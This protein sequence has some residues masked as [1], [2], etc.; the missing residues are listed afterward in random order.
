[1]MAPKQILQAEM[2]LLTEQGFD[3]AVGS[4]RGVSR[5]LERIASRHSVVIDEY[6]HRFVTR[7]LF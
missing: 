1:M 6:E 7:H 2:S 4:C 3:L 5:S